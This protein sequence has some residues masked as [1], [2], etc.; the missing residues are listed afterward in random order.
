MIAGLTPACANGVDRV[1]PRPRR[2]S[3]KLCYEMD[4]SERETVF[5]WFC[6]V[7]DYSRDVEKVRMEMG[8]PFR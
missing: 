4:I 6:F 1:L 8:S 7:L 2:N 3:Q 5:K